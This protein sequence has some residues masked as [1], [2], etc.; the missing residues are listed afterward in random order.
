VKTYNIH[1]FVAT[2]Q[3]ANKLRQLPMSS[4]CLILHQHDDAE[5]GITKG[6]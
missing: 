2:C 1:S 5:K 6:S 3:Q 4:L